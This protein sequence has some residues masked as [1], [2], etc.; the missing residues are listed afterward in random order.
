M[1]KRNSSLPFFI[2]SKTLK[3]TEFKRYG[4][5]CFNIA[6]MQAGA[7]TLLQVIARFVRIGRE[8]QSKH[9]LGDFKS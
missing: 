1:T 9:A 8:E 7:W 3:G 5:S 6:N 2:S 4:K